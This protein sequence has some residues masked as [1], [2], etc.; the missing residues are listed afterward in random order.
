MNE[1]DHRANLELAGHVI[2]GAQTLIT[3]LTRHAS[4]ESP[5]MMK[6][7]TSAI[8]HLIA[9]GNALAEGRVECPPK[10]A[11]LSLVDGGKSGD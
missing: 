11:R 9:Y 3:L 5:E 4:T 7:A 6:D 1:S 10:K 2:K 8:S